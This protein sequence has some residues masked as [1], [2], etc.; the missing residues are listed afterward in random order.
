MNS[1]ATD[2][3]VEK[4]ERGREGGVENPDTSLVRRLK[5]TKWKKQQKNRQG[6]TKR[7]TNK[8][9]NRKK[10]PTAQHTTKPDKRN[11]KGGGER[12]GASVEKPGTSLAR[13][14]KHPELKL[15]DQIKYPGH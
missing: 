2:L 15:K 9:G 8:A 12:G 11:R 1:W 10:G 5:H 3:A 6:E 7:K 4:E 14:F 13:Q